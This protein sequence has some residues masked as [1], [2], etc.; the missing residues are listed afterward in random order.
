[1]E[2]PCSGSSADQ[3]HTPVVSWSL[4]SSTRIIVSLSTRNSDKRWWPQAFLGDCLGQIRRSGAVLTEVSNPPNEQLRRTRVWPGENFYH[5]VRLSTQDLRGSGKY[6]HKSFI[7]NGV[8]R[9]AWQGNCWI[10]MWG[11]VVWVGRNVPGRQDFDPECLLR[12]RSGRSRRLELAT[13][14]PKARSRIRKMERA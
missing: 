6:E 13:D 3:S 9:P 14:S 1:M 11:I 12:S 10:I 4:C 5:S 8:R 7:I 2:H